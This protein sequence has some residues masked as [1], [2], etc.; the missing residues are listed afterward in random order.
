MLIKQSKRKYNYIIGKNTNV[1]VNYEYIVVNDKNSW[2]GC[3][4]NDININF[5]LKK[6]SNG[7][8][9][10]KNNKNSIPFGIGLRLCVGKLYQMQTTIA[11]LTHLIVNYQ[12]NHANNQTDIKIT[13]AKNQ[14]FTTTLNESIPMLAKPRNT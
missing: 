1:E 14:A 6:D 13:Y 4:S 12:F 3:D 10:F 8:Y 11:W 2:D 9:I 7:K 5:W